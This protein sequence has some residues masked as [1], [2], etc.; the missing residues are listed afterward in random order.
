MSQNRLV[1]LLLLLALFG[2]SIPAVTY[3]LG[4]Q[5]AAPIGV[6]LVAAVPKTKGIVPK[7]DGPFETREKAFAHAREFFREG[8]YQVTNKAPGAR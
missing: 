8:T 2:I 1:G 7:S 5:F 6:V 4:W 3:F